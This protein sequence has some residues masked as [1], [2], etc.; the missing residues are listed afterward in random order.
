MRSQPHLFRGLTAGIVGGLAASWVMNE[1]IAGAGPSLAGAVNNVLGSE[2]EQK[3]VPAGESQDST[4][5]VADTLTEIASGRHLSWERQKQAGP[6]VHYVFG[7][8]M[9]GLY[10]AAA[11]YIPSIKAA[12]GATYGSALFAAADVIAVPAL[13]LGQ[14][15]T[16]QKPGSLAE[17]WA[18]HA[19]YGVT[20][21]L[22][23]RMV[24]AVLE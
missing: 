8:I 11:E 10:G 9:G 16:E 22:V 6:V 13:R 19:V 17:Y 12:A 2:P 15:V 7:A 14:L 21:E 5:K 4:M 23:R 1:F 18:A 24:R 3:P 20:T